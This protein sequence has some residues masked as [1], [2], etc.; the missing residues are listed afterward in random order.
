[1]LAGLA[2]PLREPTR[3][4]ARTELSFAGDEVPV[5]TRDW[6]H[7]EI[8]SRAH[9]TAVINSPNLHLYTDLQRKVPLEDVIQEM[10]KNTV[11]EVEGTN[12]VAIQ[13][14][15]PDRAKAVLVVNQLAADSVKVLEHMAEVNRQSGPQRPRL[16]VADTASVP[17]RPLRPHGGEPR[18]LVLSS[19]SWSRCY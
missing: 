7:N 10:H 12:K 13:F 18:W 2:V 1:M 6:L 19:G 3:Y 5:S 16:L 14:T 17:D 4:V 8:L 15:Y 9:L 11:I